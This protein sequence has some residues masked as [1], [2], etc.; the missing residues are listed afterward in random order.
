MHSIGLSEKDTSDQTDQLRPESKIKKC[1]KK[2]DKVNTTKDQ[3][4]KPEGGRLE[5]SLGESCKKFLELF[6][7]KNRDNVEYINVDDCIKLLKINRRRIYDIINILESFRMI[8][9]LKKNEYEIRSAMCIYDIIVGIEVSIKNFLIFCI[10][11][12][13]VIT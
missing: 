10:F 9:R 4:Q 1:T 11:T 7:A 8:R 5:K 6:G 13:D 2:A 12:I 3:S